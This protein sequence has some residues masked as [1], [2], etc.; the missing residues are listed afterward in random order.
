MA[1]V[2][3]VT[4]AALGV[5]CT[6]WGSQPWHG[7]FSTLRSRPAFTSL[8]FLLYCF[9]ISWLLCVLGM[10]V[11]INAE[12]DKE[13]LQLCGQSQWTEFKKAFYIY[14]TL[15]LLLYFL[16]FNLGSLLILCTHLSLLYHHLFAQPWLN[17]HS[18]DLPWL[19]S[20][21]HHPEMLVLWMLRG[22]YKSYQTVKLVITHF[23]CPFPLLMTLCGMPSVLVLVLTLSHP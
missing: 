20:A 18:S 2:A 6:C 10:Q 14:L 15:V 16:V 9:P 7:S 13:K 19:L 3:M 8:T 12:P 11:Y 17:T 1:L 22:N 21:S 23:P 4:A 5:L